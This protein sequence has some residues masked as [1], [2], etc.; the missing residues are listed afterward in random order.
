MR[1]D[2]EEQRDDEE[3]TYADSRE[4]TEGDPELLEAVLIETVAGSSRESLD[5][6]FD[7]ARASEY[8]NTSQIAAVEELVDAIVTRR[9]GQR[10]FPARLLRRIAHTLI[11]TPEATVKLERLWQEARA[12]G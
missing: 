9:F 7:V 6:I 8:E 11:E 12:S 2:G 10:K 1:K 3:A 5:L 4:A